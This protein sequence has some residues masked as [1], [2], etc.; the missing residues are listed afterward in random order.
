MKCQLMQCN[1]IARRP[2]MLNLLHALRLAM[3]HTGTIESELAVIE[4]MAAGK[5]TA[6]EI[7][8]YQ[9]MSAVRIARALAPGGRLY[10]VDPWPDIDGKPNPCLAIATRHFKRMG[11]TDKLEIIRDYAANSVGRLPEQL[12][13]A[14]IDGDHSREAI[15]TDWGIVAPRIMRGGI[16]CLHDVI[17]PESEPNRVFGSVAFFEEVINLDQTFEIVEKVHSLVAIRRK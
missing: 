7:G 13:F 3:P 11:V 1:F 14:F 12:D 8:T 5:K 6:L 10:C 2:R 17:V 16:V 15:Q 9:G 4:K